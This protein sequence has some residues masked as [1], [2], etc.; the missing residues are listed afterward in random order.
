MLGVASEDQ[1]GGGKKR[2]GVG[3]RE[4][5]HGRLVHD[6]HV[7]ILALDTAVQDHPGQSAARHKNSRRRFRSSLGRRL[8]KLSDGEFVQTGLR[9]KRVEPFRRESPVPEQFAD[10]PKSL[11]RPT[12]DAGQLW[13]AGFK[14]AGCGD[15]PHLAVEGSAESE[16]VLPLS[17]REVP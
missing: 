8:V 10:L 11:M 16:D 5:G 9:V 2:R 3:V 17:G 12:R 1:M 13:V 14:P 4:G 7:E 15:L 6:H